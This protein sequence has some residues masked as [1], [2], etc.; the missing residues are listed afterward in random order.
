VL[1]PDADVLSDPGTADAVRSDGVRHP[2]RR[3]VQIRR[4]LPDRKQVLIGTDGRFVDNSLHLQWPLSV[5]PPGNG[6]SE[7]ELILGAFLSR[8]ADA[9]YDRASTRRAAIDSGNVR[10]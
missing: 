5:T 10:S 7:R 1:W 4:G 2:A 9:T 6:F 3:N 8:C